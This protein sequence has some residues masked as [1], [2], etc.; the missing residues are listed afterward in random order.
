MVKVDAPSGA[1]AENLMLSVALSTPPHSRKE[2]IATLPAQVLILVPDGAA[3][4]TATLTGTFGGAAFARTG[5]IDTVPHQQRSMEIMLDGVVGSDLAVGPDLASAPSDLA[6]VH[7]LAEPPLALTNTLHLPL[8]ANQVSTTVEV[9]A[10]QL[11]LLAVYWN[12]N[13]ATIGVSD[14]AGNTWKMAPVY[15]NP[16]ATCANSNGSQ[17][18]LWYVENS[19]AGKTTITAVE[20][21]GNNPLGAF[22]LV[23]SGVALE[24]ALEAQ[25]GAA[26]NT[27]SNAM[28]V[29]SLTAAHDGDLMVALFED[30]KNGG[31]MVAGDGFRADVVDTG[32][33]AMIEDAV[34]VAKGAHAI[35][36]TLPSGT[37]DGCW[38]G[39]AAVFK[40]R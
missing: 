21:P 40:G 5:S 37:S 18:Q 19:K 32:A 14:T 4:L 17:V 9:G 25:S 11:L 33:Y 10:G 15:S 30:S 34:G 8:Q 20:T 22:L 24:N 35:G 29:P 26:A 39:A 16:V 3:R 28:A 1:A 12:W 38:V 31:T 36:A 2:A 6:A 13:A 23:Y 27:A 7:D